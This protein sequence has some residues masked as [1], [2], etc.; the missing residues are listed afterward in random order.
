M[1]QYVIGKDLSAYSVEK[2]LEWG[3]HMRKKIGAYSRVLMLLT[4]RGSVGGAEEKW[5]D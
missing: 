2:S 5:R 3:K 1:N 4:I